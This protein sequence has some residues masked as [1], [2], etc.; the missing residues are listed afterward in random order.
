MPEARVIPCLA[1]MLE[2]APYKA[3]EK[4]ATGKAKGVR[5]GP[6]RKGTS[7]A[8]SKDKAHSP[9]AEGDTD[10]EEEERDFAPDGG[11]KKRVASATLEV[12]APKRGKGSLADNSA[13]D[14]DDSPERR[15]R[16]KPR[17][18]S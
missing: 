16:A 11:R 7:D 13:W 8:T 2:P 12:E 18:A 3:P 17:A 1:K 4:K 14:V 6:R 15:P 9:A 10:E 5:S